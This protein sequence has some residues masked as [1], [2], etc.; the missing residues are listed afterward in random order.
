MVP[1]MDGEGNVRA[2]CF[3]MVS[4]CP[5]TDYV[6]GS[7]CRRRCP[8]ELEPGSH[9]SLRVPDVLNCTRLGGRSSLRRT[10]L[11]QPLISSTGQS[12]QRTSPPWPLELQQAKPRSDCETLQR[13]SRAKW[14]RKSQ[15]AFH[16]P[17][18]GVRLPMEC[19]GFVSGVFRAK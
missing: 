2:N 9:T 12:V 3:R 11:S 19:D 15:F 1:S 10:G 18:M 13:R 6:H 4:S 8:K 17:H 16:P 14:R 5:R 7:V